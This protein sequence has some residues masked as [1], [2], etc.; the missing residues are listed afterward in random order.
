M[1]YFVFLACVTMTSISAY[2]DNIAFTLGIKEYQANSRTSGRY[3][4]TTNPN[5]KWKVQMT[6]T[7]EGPNAST[8]YWLER[9]D[10]G[11]VSKA[12][13]INVNSGVM[14]T[15]AWSSAS[16]ATVYLTAENNNYNNITYTVQGYWD[17]E[18]GK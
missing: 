4:E 3:R 9:Y 1:L 14:Y 13:T 17:E 6:K 10:G 7:Y 5:N 15:P 8:T 18:T 2:D 12:I 16:Q 11:N